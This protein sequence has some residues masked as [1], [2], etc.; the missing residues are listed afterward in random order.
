M[1][2]PLGKWQ[3]AVKE[4]LEHLRDRALHLVDSRR[5]LKK[6]GIDFFR[7]KKREGGSILVQIRDKQLTLAPPKEERSPEW[8]SGI[9]DV[10]DLAN[11]R[12]GTNAKIIQERGKLIIRQ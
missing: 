11:S 4:V 8:I 7:S 1:H 2:Y 5:I 12:H 9:Q 10:I 3:T 6:H